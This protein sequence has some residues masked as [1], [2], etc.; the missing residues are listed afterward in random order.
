LSSIG[1]VVVARQKGGFRW[2]ELGGSLMGMLFRS[3]IHS[4][5]DEVEYGDERSCW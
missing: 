4:E 2:R 5:A 1:M 3:G